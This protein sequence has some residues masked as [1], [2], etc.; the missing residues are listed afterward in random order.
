M[1]F[2]T[3]AKHLCE[4]KEVSCVQKCSVLF[5][6]FFIYSLAEHYQVLRDLFILE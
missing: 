4:V 1:R 2:I 3:L 6:K 5:T